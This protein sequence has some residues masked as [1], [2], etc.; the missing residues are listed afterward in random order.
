MINMLEV[1]PAVKQTL[2]HI[3]RYYLHPQA[4]ATVV[5]KIRKAEEEQCR[6]TS[7]TSGVRVPVQMA[8]DKMWL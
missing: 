5:Y 3:K 4:A 7:V 6:D 8:D 2:I 1:T